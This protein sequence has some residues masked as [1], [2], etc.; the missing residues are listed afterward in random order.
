MIMIVK[1]QAIVVCTCLINNH[2]KVM[3]QKERC[4]CMLIV[5]PQADNVVADQDAC[6]HEDFLTVVAV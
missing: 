6:Q 2:A 3:V 5:E 1:F 4:M